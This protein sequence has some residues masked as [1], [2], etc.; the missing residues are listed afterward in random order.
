MVV[1]HQF[2]HLRLCDAGCY[3]VSVDIKESGATKFS[4]NVNPHVGWVSENALS[5]MSVM[6]LF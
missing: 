2:L 5:D 1:E 3:Y 4:L 6:C